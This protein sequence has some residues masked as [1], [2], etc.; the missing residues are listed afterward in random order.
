MIQG[1]P[2]FGDNTQEIVDTIIKSPIEEILYYDSMYD[3]INYYIDKKIVIIIDNE[4]LS[5]L[6][7][8]AFNYR[9]KTCYIPYYT[10][11]LYKLD[12]KEYRSNNKGHLILKEN[13]LYIR[14]NYNYKKLEINEG[15]ISLLIYDIDTNK[16]YKINTDKWINE[17]EF[18]I[19]KLYNLYLDS[20]Y[21]DDD[22]IFNKHSG[23]YHYILRS[24]KAFKNKEKTLR[25]VYKLQHFS[26]N[27]TYESDYRDVRNFK[28]EE[29]VQ[30]VGFRDTTELY[31]IRRLKFESY[32]YCLLRQGLKP[33]NTRFLKTWNTLGVTRDYIKY[34]KN[35]KLIFK[36]YWLDE[37]NPLKNKSW[38][39]I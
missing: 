34:G 10:Y 21:T 26:I 2:F 9:N 30:R 16:K 29:V 32:L 11:E 15:K 28:Q 13:T 38:N 6:N 7:D 22:F 36:S 5:W 25:E 4:W 1:I 3:M 35:I 23:G 17:K 20:C 18:D 24:P 12:D 31:K 39:R 33:S 14:H 37:Y 19:E 27:S 8:I